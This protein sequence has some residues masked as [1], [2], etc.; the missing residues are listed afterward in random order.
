[1]QLKNLLDVRYYLG[2]CSSSSFIDYSEAFQ[3]M[4]EFILDRN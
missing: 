2:S 4:K 3:A 1:M